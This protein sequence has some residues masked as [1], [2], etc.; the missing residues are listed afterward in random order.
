M[1]WLSR[2][3]VMMSAT[4]LLMCGSSGARKAVSAENIVKPGSRIDVTGK[5]TA[6][7]DL[8]AG[9][10]EA[11]FTFKQDGDKLTGKYKGYFGERDLK[12]K[13]TGN[14]I[15]FE[16]PIDEG[17][18]VYTGELD[19][20]TLEG[21]TN[22][23]DQTSGTWIAKREV[24]ITGTWN[25]ET[26]ISGNPGNPVFRFKQDGEKITGTYMGLFGEQKLTGTL[27][28]KALEF[29]FEI[30]LGGEKGAVVYTGTLDRDS[31]KGTAE[32][33]D[34]LSGTWTAKREAVKK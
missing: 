31:M 34:N 25:A 20:E 17:N 7:I 2:L 29:R 11:V 16:F 9:K 27:K 13:V 18:A 12:G 14:K 23:A 28:N 33:G 15:E 6:R 3:M 26:D 30:E 5:W 10:G 24:D 32:Y 22:Y 19:G 1:A 21:T 8:D 4:G